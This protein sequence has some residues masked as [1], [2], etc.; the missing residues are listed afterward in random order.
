MISKFLLKLNVVIS[1][2]VAFRVLQPCAANKKGKKDRERERKGKCNCERRIKKEETHE[3]E[4]WG[5]EKGKFLY[6]L[7]RL[8][9]DLKVTEV[10]IINFI[11]MMWSCG[12][13]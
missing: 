5:R 11:E 7:S 2:V 9:K 3:W 4:N 10:M 8:V 12:H 6:P 1:Q 13:Q